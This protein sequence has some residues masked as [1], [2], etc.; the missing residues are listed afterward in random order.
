[1]VAGLKNFIMRFYVALILIFLY[2]PIAVLVVLSFN[3]SRSRSV[4]GGFTLEWYQ[5]LFQ[6]EAIMMA[7]KNTVVI[8]FAAAGIATVI[9]LLG[10]L[11]IDAMRKRN[12]AIVMGV[13]NIPMLNADIVT[14]LALMLFFVKFMPL[15]FSSILLS[16]VTFC[17][18]Y[19]ILSIMPKLQRMDVAVY[20]AA[21]DLGANA[22]TAFF[23][24]TLPDIMPAVFSGF[25]MALTMSM[26]DFI[27]S[28]FT[29][30]AGINT[31]STLIYGELKRGIKPE[32]YA[33]STLIFVV[34]LII[35][36]CVNFLPRI[37]EKRQKK[38]AEFQ[39]S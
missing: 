3:N 9:G 33:L 11:G 7:L 26:D 12:Y 16:H 36:L 15:G 2:A 1:M 10:A 18:P 31:L 14:G 13:G 34:I 30:G 17:I 6:S 19:V 8:G 38:Q 23:K 20:E 21:R 37:A 27:V 39:R 24:V 4:W 32:L 5:V 25:F 29:K 35:L 22:M 28:Y